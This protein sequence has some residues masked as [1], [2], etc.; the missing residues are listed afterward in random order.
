MS[1]L[2][3]ELAQCRQYAERGSRLAQKSYDGLEKTLRAEQARIDAAERDMP[4]RIRQTD[5][6][7]KQRKGFNRLSDDI[8]KIRGDLE[9]L[10]RQQQDFSIIVFG[11][12][13]AGKST[14]MEILT[15]GNGKSIGNG[16][17]RTTRDVRSYYWNGLK[18][19]DVPG[20]CAFAGDADKKLALDAAKNAD[21]I[22]FLITQDGVQ[23]EEAGFLAELKSF[24]KPVLGIVNAKQAFDINRK[25]IALPRMKKLLDNTQML[26]EIVRQFKEYARN[27]NQ[28]WSDIPFVYA[29]LNS[30]FQAQLERGNDP[31]VYEASKMPVVENFIIDKVRSDGKFLRIKTFIDIAAV[32]T[33][34]IIGAL[35]D[36]GA[37][38]LF[39]SDVW[40]DN[41]KRL[42]EWSE[43]FDKRAAQ[44]FSELYEQSR[45]KLERR[46]YDFAETHYDDEKAGDKWIAEFQRIDFASDYTELLEELSNE[47]KRKLDEFG[48]Q[49]RSELGYMPQF[50]MPTVKVD[51]PSTTE[52]GKYAMMVL[53]NLLMFIPGV[54]WAARIAIAIGSIILSTFFGNKEEKIREAKAELRKQLSEPSQAALAKMHAD[55]VD[56]CI[57]EIF[58]EGIGGFREA[59]AAQGEMLIELGDAQCRTAVELDQNYYDL[60]FELLDEAFRYKR[61]LDI[62]IT[63]D[64]LARIPGE[65]FTIVA[66][67]DWRDRKKLSSLLGEKL[68]I[69]PSNEDI[70]KLVSQVLGCGY[71]VERFPVGEE[72]VGVVLR[73]EKAVDETRRLL[74]QQIA[75]VPIMKG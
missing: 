26:D 75:E 63:V 33:Q 54:G 58:E 36:A 44:K 61:D 64:N 53:P 1:V 25:K 52:W 23:A 16:S 38:T 39:A 41:L 14:L 18:I 74:A 3:E 48:D 67:G 66:E 2:E 60:N 13:M 19:T 12:T 29:H 32:P 59:L 47:C 22:L 6:I 71:S 42:D 37:T 27:H 49:L 31:E 45:K 9:T 69:V 4:D 30:A 40:W 43:R 62:R 11:R 55:I 50:E 15:H 68:Q 65:A 28:D 34:K 57:K 24:G 35:F 21:L 17:Q 10:R 56:V 51:L 7:K 8:G 72:E 70:N 73:P 5:L 46:I 20:V